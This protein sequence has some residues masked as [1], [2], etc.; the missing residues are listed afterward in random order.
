MKEIK[1]AICN[2]QKKSPTAH[3]Q[4]FKLE[5]HPLLIECLS[6]IESFEFEV[7]RVISW[8]VHNPYINKS[9]N[10]DNKTSLDSIREQVERWVYF[11]NFDI[12]ISCGA[13]LVAAE[14]L[15]IPYKNDFI[16]ISQESTNWPQLNEKMELSHTTH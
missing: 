12:K 15:D 3:Y 14:C 7:K 2:V 6:M 8:F 9:N 4:G 10:L 1:E 11:L 16:Y 13:V 5:S